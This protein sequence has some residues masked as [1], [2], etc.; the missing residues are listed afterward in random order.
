MKITRT[1]LDLNSLSYSREF[2]VD[3]STGIHL[4]EI[5]EYIAK[6]SGIEK[7]HTGGVKLENFATP[8]FLW[9]H[10]MSRVDKLEHALSVEAMRMEMTHRS[11][12][13]FPGE[14]YW[15]REC[16]EVMTGG[17][18]AQGHS[19]SRGHL[20][21]YF[22]PDA[23]DYVA[24][25]YV[26]WKLTW[27]SSKRSEP[28]KLDSKNGIW[29]WPVQ[30]MFN[31]YGLGTTKAK[32]IAL[33]IMGEYMPGMPEPQ[34]YEIEL[35]FTQQELRRNKMMIAANMEEA[36]VRKLTRRLLNEE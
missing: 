28:S 25:Q 34:P 18:H 19:K 26:E 11:N 13:L 29:R 16:D 32:I 22:T 27:K 6:T 4:M 7:P 20:G 23:Y 33:H 21:V 10:V 14:L 30:C 36:A 9:E 24:D 2:D 12:L 15:C 17:R 3:R 35:E 1:P 8:G 31:C 5:V